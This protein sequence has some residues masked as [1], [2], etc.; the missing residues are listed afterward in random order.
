MEVKEDFGLLEFLFVERGPLAGWGSAA[1]GL[2][3]R[4][5]VRATGDGTCYR[6][7]ALP[8]RGNW[9]MPP[10]PENSVLL[11]TRWIDRR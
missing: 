4:G 7:R 5:P 2:P 6:Q 11:L 8:K 10:S 1:R 9:S 3:L